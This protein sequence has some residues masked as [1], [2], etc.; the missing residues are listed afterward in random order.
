MWSE[1]CNI[2]YRSRNLLA[3]KIGGRLSCCKYLVN[4]DSRYSSVVNGYPGHG[5]STQ[6]PRRIEPNA[7]FV[8]VLQIECVSKLSDPVLIGC[9]GL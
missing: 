2:A 1:H 6:H 5:G 7:S 3:V 4:E 9:F 8:F